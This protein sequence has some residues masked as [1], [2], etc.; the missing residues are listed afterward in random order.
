MS[1][2]LIGGPS[3]PEVSLGELQSGRLEPSLLHLFRVLVSLHDPLPL[4]SLF[5]ASPLSFSHLRT[6]FLSPSGR[7]SSEVHALS[8][9]NHISFEQDGSVSLASFQCSSP[10]SNELGSC[11]LSFGS[12]LSRPS[13]SKAM[14]TVFCARSAP[15]SAT[16]LLL[17]T[18]VALSSE[19][20]S[21]L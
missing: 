14:R 1:E 21:F 13:C 11:P 6:P 5:A 17:E 3:L 2:G 7:H 9:L 15:C 18:D 16:R 12:A 10:R 20:Y 19:M 4:L 8:G